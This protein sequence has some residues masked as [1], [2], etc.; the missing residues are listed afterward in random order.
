MQRAV[1]E[2]TQALQRNDAI[3]AQRQLLAA[4]ALAPDNAEI[5]RLL[6]VASS[7]QGRYA[8]AV[9]SLRESLRLREDEPLTH[10]SLGRALG[11][12]GERSAAAAAFAR[13][14]EL[15]PDVAAFWYNRGKILTE[16]ARDHDALPALAQAV[17]LDPDNR[18]AAFLHAR[19]LRVTGHGDEAAALYRSLLRAQ[20][21]SAEAWLG[22][23][24][25]KSLRFSADDVAA[26]ERLAQSALDADD[27]ISIRFALARGYEDL[28]RFDDALRTYVDGNARVRRMFP[29]D[30]A[31]FS[32]RVDEFIA[33]SVPPERRA[34]ATLG[35]EVIF[36]VSMPRSGSSLTEQILAS[37]PQVDGAG[38]LPHLPAV[39]Q[40]ESQRRGS[41]FPRWAG[42]ASAADWQR[43]GERYLER[44][45]RW[46]ERRPFFT[47]K[48]PDNW[49]HVGAIAAMLPGARIVICERDPVETA[50]ACFRQLFSGGG[51]A[52][53]YDFA[54]IAA[55][56]RDFQ[57]AAKHWRERFPAQTREQRYEALQAD[58]EG[59]VRDLLAFCNLPF[60]AACLRFH[61]TERS[62]RTASASQV[63]EP[64][65]RD[66][67][68][69]PKY[70]AL[71]DPL[72]IA[73][74]LPSLPQG[75]TAGSVRDR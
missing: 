28:G 3:G 31:Q 50:L 64:L 51:Q 8:D 68:R 1:N 33:M 71:L 15:A 25:L 58:L 55:Y 34:P 6:G 22:L 37:H 41:L 45:A 46:R 13:A 23:G 4:L 75:P 44:T 60:D 19:T 67:A 7:A 14:C 30:A 39:L 49:R 38:E 35:S 63:R 73:L 66:T 43:L 42:D 62:V 69:A 65:R 24:D 12:L 27:A 72:R 29:W 70:G 18:N 21:G 61:E 74:G 9:E 40:E 10:N 54:D 52:F 16:D 17:R 20:R 36:I 11:H 2:A 5:H 56:T 59:E 57:R 32:A 48:L 26:M 53:S 47:D